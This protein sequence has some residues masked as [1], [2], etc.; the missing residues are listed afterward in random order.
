VL[1]V[2]DNPRGQKSLPRVEKTHGQGKAWTILAQHV[3][4]AVYFMFKR[5]TAFEMNKFLHG[6][7]RWSG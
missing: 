3:A 5:H 1:C 4:R 6:E 7:G 2:R